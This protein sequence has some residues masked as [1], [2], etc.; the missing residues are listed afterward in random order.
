MPWKWPCIPSNSTWQFMWH[1][2][3]SDNIV[4][5]LLHGAPWYQTSCYQILWTFFFPVLIHVHEVWSCEQ[6][7]WASQHLLSHDILD[8]STFCAYSLISLLHQNLLHAC[9]GIL[10][11]PHVSQSQVYIQT[12]DQFL[13]LLNC[14]ISKHGLYFPLGHSVG[15]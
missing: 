7:L 14:L 11:L 13:P 3:S 6:C 12:L 9:T 5:C 1:L 4:A 8:T 15:M 2:V 10:Q